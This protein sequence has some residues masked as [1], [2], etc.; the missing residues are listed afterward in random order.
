MMRMCLKSV[1]VFHIVCPLTEG[2]SSFSSQIRTLR[3][4]SSLGPAPKVWKPESSVYLATVLHSSN[5]YVF[6][7][8]LTV[9]KASR[10][11]TR[12]IRKNKQCRIHLREG[13]SKGL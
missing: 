4:I 6:Y 5:K 12:I 9:F 1:F 10:V 8:L 2:I 11:Q 13:P 3:E 7:S